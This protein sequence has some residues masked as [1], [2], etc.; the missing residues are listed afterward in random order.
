MD[1]LAR[2]EI[3]QHEALEQIVVKDQ[4]NVEVFGFRADAA[5]SR[6]KCETSPEFQQERLDCPARPLSRSA[7]NNL[8]TPGRPRNSSMTGSRTKSRG[9]WEGARLPR[10]VLDSRAV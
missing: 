8:P 7:S 2:F 6:N 10:F 1:Q 5:L 9:V 4:I 3:E